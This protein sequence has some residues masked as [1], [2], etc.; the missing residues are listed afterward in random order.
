MSEYLEEEQQAVSVSI[1][2]PVYNAGNYIADCLNSIQRQTCEDFEIICVDDG[3]TDDSSA[4]VAEIATRDPRIRLIQQ[5]NRGA[6]GARNTGFDLA[7][8]QFVTFVDADDEVSPTFLEV[9]GGAIVADD[10]D[11]ALGNTYIVR[12]DGIKRVKY[13]EQK[14]DVLA[15]GSDHEKYNLLSR[16][17]PHG[18][19]F[20][21]TFLVE[22]RI[23]FYE[24]ITYEDYQH[25]LECV[26]KDPKLSLRSS[27]V[28]LYK[29][30]PFSISSGSQILRSFNI[31]SRLV[32]TALSLRASADSNIRGLAE[33]TFRMQFRAR[34]MRHILALARSKDREAV[35]RAF[36]QLRQGLIPHQS[37][38]RKK[39]YGYVLLVYE[40]ILQGTVEE[41]I[42][43]IDWGEGKVPLNIYVD[44]K[45]AVPKIYAAPEE[46][47]S[48]QREDMEVF[49]VSDKVR[50][51]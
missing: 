38:L 8:G 10:A 13:P 24:G 51:K 43:L 16:N 50:K 22:N 48:I 21:R 23:R 17:A 34:I 47:P 7:T 40:L 42:K 12:G 15:R 26:C 45:P 29:R 27:F 39:L 36:Y 25:W 5:E 49:D 35:E 37:Q 2:I 6:S 19:L 44:S 9:L 41:L 32:Q 30:N 1:I 11:V 46:F 31:E 14:T 3:S 18:K 20:R 33:K 4:V 28:Y